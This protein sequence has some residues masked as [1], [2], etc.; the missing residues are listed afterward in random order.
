MSARQHR[1]T[2]AQLGLCQGRSPACHKQCAPQQPTSDEARDV[3]PVSP[4]MVY[5]LG[6]VLVVLGIAMGT[7]LGSWLLHSF[8]TEIRAALLG[9]WD[10]LQRL[11][12]ATRHVQG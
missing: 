2:C 1:Y 5:F 12:W 11:Y 6:A 9:A 10:V 8:D 7:A 3:P 4:D